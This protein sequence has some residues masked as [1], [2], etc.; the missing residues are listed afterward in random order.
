MSFRGSIPS[1]S[2]PLSTLRAALCSTPRMT[3]GQCGSLFLHCNGLSPSIPCRSPGALRVDLYAGRHRGHHW[4][5][6]LWAAERHGVIA[7]EDDLPIVAA[8]DQ[9]KG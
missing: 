7:E 4:V 8:L 2:V 5:D 1:L 6:G 9:L 3:R